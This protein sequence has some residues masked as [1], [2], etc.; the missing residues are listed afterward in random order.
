M[1][2]PVLHLIAGPNGAGKS[3]F[4]ELVVAPAT[5]L[6]FV[7][8]DLI[9][10][11]RW[12]VNAAGHAYDA[13]DLAAARR[14]KLISAKKSF[15]TETVFSHESKVDLAREATAAGYLV[16]LH[17]IAV[18]ENLAVARVANRAEN[19]GH[20]V[21]EEKIRERYRRLWPLV[22]S[23]VALVDTAVVYDNT[24]AS[25]PF[26][27]IARFENGKR[28]GTPEWPSWTPAALKANAPR[29][30]GGGGSGI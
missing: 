14:T 26:R 18:P 2:D 10:A 11:R 12:R 23:A 20:A 6:E 30:R 3:T 27:V 19:G 8:A 25:D 17:V 13:A 16:T 21:P 7:N 24:S 5:H 15:V 28:L 29:R 9:A 22:R 4:Y 1:S